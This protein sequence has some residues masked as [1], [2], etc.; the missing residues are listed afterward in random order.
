MGWGAWATTGGCLYDLVT[1]ASG[2][3]P[4]PALIVF[5][6][7]DTDTINGENDTFLVPN[8]NSVTLIDISEGEWLLI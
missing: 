8:K 1:T 4:V 6:P 2:Q 5:H 7:N 3:V